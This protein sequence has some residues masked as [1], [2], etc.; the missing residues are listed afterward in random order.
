MNSNGYTL[1]NINSLH[2]DFKDFLTKFRGVSTK[3]LKGYLG[4]FAYIKKL[5]YTV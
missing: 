1:S 5:N 2:S 4:W 3:H